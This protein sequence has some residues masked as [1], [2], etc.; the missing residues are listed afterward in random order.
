MTETL[1]NRMTWMEYR[2]RVQRD[3][4]TVFLPVGA[5][6]QHGPH[7]PLG[8]IFPEGFGGVTHVDGD[9][10]RWL[11]QQDFQPLADRSLHVAVA[12]RR[13]AVLAGC[14][15]ART[16]G[17]TIDRLL[18]AYPLLNSVIHGDMQR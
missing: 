12:G 5:T 14:K 11:R 18:A 7:L 15:R 6:E 9:L 2:D 4:A 1:M 3:E 16:G 10:C 13:R 8:T 17:P